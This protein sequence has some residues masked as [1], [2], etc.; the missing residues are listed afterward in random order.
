MRKVRLTFLL[1]LLF[2][3]VLLWSCCSTGIAIGQS[4][5]PAIQNGD[6]LVI[7]T[8][9]YEIERFDLITFEHDNRMLIKR[10]IGLPHDKIVIYGSWILVNGRSINEPYLYKFFQYDAFS[11]QLKENEY[12]VLGDNRD[13]SYDS[14]FFGP[15][16]TENIEGE[17]LFKW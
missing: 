10:V 1:L 7:T 2:L 3:S 15:V 11:V 13:I 5:F 9:W 14:R 4:M 12:F 6:Y 8:K 17:F 16:K